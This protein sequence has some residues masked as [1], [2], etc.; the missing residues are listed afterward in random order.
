[1]F[2]GESLHPSLFSFAAFSAEIV[3]CKPHLLSYW[4]IW[5]NAT[6]F[7]RYT[8]RTFTKGAIQQLLL[9][10]SAVIVA[11]AAATNANLFLSLNSLHSLFLAHFNHLLQILLI[12]IQIIHLP[13]LARRELKP[14]F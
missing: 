11:R 14:T 2:I 3:M 6:S 9:L 12:F 1:M 10:S 4:A 5:T 8:G 13:E 7:I